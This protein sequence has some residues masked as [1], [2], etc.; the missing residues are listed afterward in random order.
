MRLASGVEASVDSLTTSD[1]LHRWDRAME[2]SESALVAVS[3]PFASDWTVHIGG[4]RTFPFPRFAVRQL[5]V[6]LCFF[7]FSSPCPGLPLG[8]DCKRRYWPL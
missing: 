5:L 4:N 3:I 1:P 6:F 8:P 7:L 2:I